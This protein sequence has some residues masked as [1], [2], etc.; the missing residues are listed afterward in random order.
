VRDATRCGR[1]TLSTS[2]LAEASFDF[3]ARRRVSVISLV[4]ADRDAR[5]RRGRFAAMTDVGC[6]TQ[7]AT[8]YWLRAW[9]DTG[10][11]GRSDSAGERIRGAARGAM[12]SS[13]AHGSHNL[14]VAGT[15]P[16]DMLACVRRLEGWAA[17][18]SSLP[19][20]RCGRVCAAGG[21]ADVH[22]TD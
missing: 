5:A 2:E 16:R 8:C 9:S 21:R 22:R 13:V 14:I 17:D 7:S 12:A 19:T 20:A 1:K 10:R 15:D 4:G 6:S 11:R 18:G 3:S